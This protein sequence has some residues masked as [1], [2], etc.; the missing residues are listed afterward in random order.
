MQFLF[1]LLSV[2]FLLSDKSVF[3]L[4][5]EITDD[6]RRFTG[7]KGRA[8]LLLQHYAADLSSDAPVNP[9]ETTAKKVATILGEGKGV[10]GFRKTGKATLEE[11]QIMVRALDLAYQYYPLVDNDFFAASSADP[12]IKKHQAILWGLSKTIS[13]KAVQRMYE[14]E[15][16]TKVECDLQYEVRKALEPPSNPALEKKFRDD[17]QTLKLTNKLLLRHYVDTHASIDIIEALRGSIKLGADCDDI[18]CVFLNYQTFRRNASAQMC[19]RFDA[20]QLRYRD[21]IT[22]KDRLKATVRLLVADAGLRG[23]DSALTVSE[24]LLELMDSKS[25]F[26]KSVL[27][28]TQSALTFNTQRHS[29]YNGSFFKVVNVHQ[30]HPFTGSTSVAIRRPG[31]EVSKLSAAVKAAMVGLSHVDYDIVIGTPFF[32]NDAEESGPYLLRPHCWT[33]P[34]ET[35]GAYNVTHKVNAGIFESAGI[36]IAGQSVDVMGAHDVITHGGV[37][38]PANIALNLTLGS[39]APEELHSF[40]SVVKEG[41][42]GVVTLHGVGGDF[43]SQDILKLGGLMGGA[44]TAGDL[45][46]LMHYSPAL[47]SNPRF[48]KFLTEWLG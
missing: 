29:M 39:L 15:Q 7:Q 41:G 45:F 12:E 42:K 21:L 34:G 13:V 25:S 18:T 26:V 32:R 8:I 11:K 14:Q 2:I 48:L 33:D 10:G 16:R 27:D 43:I 44:I 1:V 37:A 23:Y 17:R 9:K 4:E 3:A 38:S 31:G 30:Y 47:S 20:A 28:T 22:D 46:L 36:T 5:A 35:G 19:G 24:D 6:L 40:I